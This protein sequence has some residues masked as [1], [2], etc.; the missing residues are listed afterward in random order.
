MTIR[1]QD[2]CTLWT[3]D[4]PY[5]VY[6]IDR[7]E[8]RRLT[9]HATVPL[10]SELEADVLSV[11]GGFSR[12]AHVFWEGGKTPAKRLNELFRMIASG[13]LDEMI[14]A[15]QMP[16]FPHIDHIFEAPMKVDGEQSPFAVIVAARSM[17]RCAAALLKPGKRGRVVDVPLTG[18]LAG[19]DRI[20]S[21]FEISDGLGSNEN[22]ST[23][24]TEIDAPSP[25]PRVAFILAGVGV[26]CLA[27]IRWNSRFCDGASSTKLADYFT[28]ISAITARTIA[29]RVRDTRTDEQISP[30]AWDFSA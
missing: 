3:D 24:E 27:G 18:L 29:D 4:D 10:T 14:R 30:K 8:V 19:L 26:A 11:I 7:D 6:C 15:V 23:D 12:S 22:L 17:Q 21:R 25:S 16:E 9:S 1:E 5:S 28:A 2:E 13:N 20:A